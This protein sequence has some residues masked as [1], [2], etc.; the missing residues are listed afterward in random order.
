VRLTLYV[1]NLDCENE[2]AAI[3]RGLRAMPG[4]RALTV[5]PK[6]AK[7]ELEID[8]KVLDERGAAET[9]AALGFPTRR[10]DDA[11]GPPVPWKNRKVLASLASGAVL[12]AGWIASMGATPRPIVFSVYV[13]SILVGGYFFAREAT[14]ELFL[15]RRVGIE[16]LMTVAAVVATALGQPGEGA[17]LAFL[18][19][20][21]EAAE[22]YTEEKTRSAVKA[23]M[24]LMP[25]VAIVRRDGH[26]RELPAEELRIGD[27][28]VVR[29][30]SSVVTDGVVL[31]G[32]SSLD[33]SPVTGESVPVDKKVGDVV[34]AGT[35][36]GEGALEVHATKTFA[37]NTIARII[38]LVEEAQ[39]KKAA[40]E[41]FIERFGH[42][43]SP[44]VLLV[45]ALFAI[46][47]PLA[48]SAPW[49]TWLLRATVFVV[50]AAPCALVISIPITLV[51]TLGTAA[52]NGVLIKGGNVVEDLAKIRVVALDKTG[53]L[54][55]GR[56]EVTDIVAVE[57]FDRDAML[58]LASAVEQSSQHPVAR[59]I[60][61]YTIE[62]GIVCTSVITE[63]KSLTA[64]GVRARV[65][66]REVHVG[67][68]RFFEVE[69]GIDL[70]RH[71]DAIATLQD[72]AKTVVLVATD[73][74]F[75]GYLAFRDRVR[76]NARRA[77]A[78]L[79]AARVKVAMLTGDN[80]RAARVVAAALGID[81]L[82]TGLKP[83]DKAR[84]VRDLAKSV[85]HVAMVGDGVND[86]PALAAA[87][88][89]IAMG[90]AGTD[91]AL[92]TADV[93]LMAD[94]LGKL[95]YALQLAQ[96][97]A[98]VIKQNL[99]LSIAVISVLVAGTLLGRFSL[100]IAV[101][102]HELSELVVIVSGLRMLRS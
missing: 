17:M 100:P 79:H 43:Y 96:R 73:G 102:G 80:E 82:H 41:R 67:S 27:V 60:V 74:R 58:A 29:P 13:A 4:V 2:A 101:I 24:K 14:E 86:A 61:R 11:S 54:T 6:A 52:R 31:V 97:T 36:N 48:F 78:A 12:L 88:V 47:P 71:G 66:G 15:E 50:A 55:E 87:D 19:S 39:E 7:V 92:E 37:D 51:A 64:A 21:S 3:E 44:A 5:S 76:D 75:A 68:P 35:I 90:A 16:L 49:A 77:I 99:A 34:L 70:A 26:E 46:V 22:G 20:I 69:L 53:T 81:T 98:R 8:E 84:I 23:L 38:H 89:G 45:G 56:P 93:A 94:D 40:S 62:S 63:F 28:F 10:R 57:G 91:V 18:Y 30:G 42:R 1:Q 33:E 83:E 59:A 72:A 65:D 95:A 85:G 32:D 25:K 9:L